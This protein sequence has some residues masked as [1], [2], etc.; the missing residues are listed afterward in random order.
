[1]TTAAAQYPK[2]AAGGEVARTDAGSFDLQLAYVAR[3]LLLSVSGL[4]ER[5]RQ[6][7]NDYARGAS[8]HGE[9][10]F[11]LI[12]FRSLLAIARR[13]RR[14]ED[15]EAIAE[16]VRA[17]INRGAPPSSIELAFDGETGAT[18]PCDVEQ[19]AFEHSPNPITWARCKAALEKQLAATRAALDAV[20]ADPRFAGATP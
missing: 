1:M 12:T 7:L 4:D 18:G 5:E 6:L 15:R 20:N 19:R 2:M 13:S 14:T 10:R 16:L 9:P 3:R 8:L 17:E 11:R